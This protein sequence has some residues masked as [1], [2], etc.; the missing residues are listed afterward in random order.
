MAVGSLATT[1]LSTGSVDVSYDPATDILGL[2]RP[3]LIR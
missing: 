3:V 2:G 1:L